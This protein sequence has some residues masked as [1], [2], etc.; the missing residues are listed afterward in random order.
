MTDD[1]RAQRN[2]RNGHEPP[3]GIRPPLIRREDVDAEIGGGGSA[4]ERFERL[5]GRVLGTGEREAE[6]NTR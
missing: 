2:G 1:Q 5:V 4:W 6:R 3:E